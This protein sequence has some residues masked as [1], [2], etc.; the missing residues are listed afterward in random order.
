MKKILSQNQIATK[1]RRLNNQSG[2]T[3]MELLVSMAI[4]LV[5]ISSVYGLLKVSLIDRNR[6]SR[7]TDILKNARAA[8]H[9]IGRDTLNAG[10]GYNKSG[11]VVPDN[12]VSS[13]IGIPA[14]TNTDRDLITG[15]L[16]GNDLF[17]NILQTD[18]NAKTDIIAFAYR[19]VAFNSG[20][21]ISLNNA[22]AA[23]SAPAT[24]RLQTPT[25][26]AANAQLYDLYLVESDS[27]QVA[28][29]ATNI[30]SG[31][32]NI[33]IA[34][35]D[36]L[37]LNQA[38]NGTGM[39]GSILKKCSATVTQNCTT[40]VASVK[41]FYWVT[42]K[43]KSDGTLVRTTY[44]NNTSG[45]SS[46]QIQEMPLAYNVQDLQLQYIL[47]NGT[48]TDDPAA[49]PDHIRGTTDDTPSDFNLVRQIVVN[50]KVQAPENDEQTKAPETITLTSTF[51]TRNLEYDAG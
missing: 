41:R 1:A 17:I 13:K 9:L 48:V 35:G 25:S 18:P 46:T 8:L 43:V 39:D 44:G 22:A 47:E 36:P 27:S 33:D 4:F 11:A 23:P 16:G 6:S 42:Y 26:G 49:G 24:V 15:I 3:L 29:M 5:V 20:N 40:Y 12:F 30:P 51:C 28:V 50:I 31:G 14:D 45:S 19:D 7:R 32:I 10:L 38:L 37:G 21:V 2:F 34:P